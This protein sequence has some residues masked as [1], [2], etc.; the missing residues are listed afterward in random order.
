MTR[1]T[2]SK[3]NNQRV[4]LDGYTFDSQAEARRY[5]ELC[6]LYDAGEITDLAVH[7]KYPLVVNGQVVANYL[8]DFS[9]T[10]ADGREV[11]ED[12]KGVRTDVYRLKRKLVRA[13]Y[14]IDIVEVQP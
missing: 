14:G 8:A 1:L 11:V 13:L 4:V 2:R 12:V 10:V 3:Y 5:R 7:P 9:Y 6:L